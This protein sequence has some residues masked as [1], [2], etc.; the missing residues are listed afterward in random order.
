[1]KKT[2]KYKLGT[3][4]LVGALGL[5]GASVL[6]GCT[7]KKLQPRLKLFNHWPIHDGTNIYSVG[8]TI[9]IKALTLSMHNNNI[10]TYTI[11]LNNGK[12]IEFYR[13]KISSL[14]KVFQEPISIN[15][16]TSKIYAETTK[17]KQYSEIECNTF[18][19]FDN[20]IIKTDE[21]IIKK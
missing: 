8:E 10:S 7:L 12:K 11:C 4:L 19:E 20:K 14:N 9:H 3:V 17:D 21:F 6:S 1:M 13:T 15:L 18:L 2:L 5:G 16:D